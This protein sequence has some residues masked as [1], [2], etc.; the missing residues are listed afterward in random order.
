MLLLLLMVLLLLFLVLLLL[1]LQ[2]LG[3]YGAVQSQQAISCDCGGFLE[4]N[5]SQF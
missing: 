3:G 5:P 1:P 4:A 2:D